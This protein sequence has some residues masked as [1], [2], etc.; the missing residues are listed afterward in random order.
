MQNPKPEEIKDK[1]DNYLN[2][3]KRLIYAG[4]ENPHSHDKIIFQIND[5]QKLE[6]NPKDIKVHNYNI[7]HFL[8][9]DIKYEYKEV[10]PLNRGQALDYLDEGYLVE[11]EGAEY[12]IIEKRE[13]GYYWKTINTMI[14]IITLNG[15]RFRV[16]S[17][18][19]AIDRQL[20]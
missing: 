19:E 7:N 5:K 10:Y 12:P 2:M 8:G 3:I 4:Y 11:C 13:D 6:V 18:L 20:I 16:I 1:I 17:E 14:P 15:N 9:T